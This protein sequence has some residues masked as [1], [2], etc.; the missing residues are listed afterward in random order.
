MK[1]FPILACVALAVS[2]PLSAK[3]SDQ[4]GIASQREAMRVLSWMD[5]RWRGQAVTQ[6]PG[7]EHK[8]VQTER[9]GNFLDGTIKVVE[10]RGFN[11]DGS[12]GFNA[13]GVISYDPAT[14][15]YTFRSYAQGR[16]GTF[17]ISPIAGKPG[18]VWEIPVGPMTIRY[19]ATIEEG[20]WHEVG[21]RISPGA[22]PVR[23]FDMML[24]R[25]GDSD[26]PEAGALTPR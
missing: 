26:W 11:A 22:E 5:G 4:A 15:A 14:K 9:I 19:T 17:T 18:Y 2:A 12:V 20:K 1:P 16:A 13:F 10:G 24:T 8:V 25:V 7:G 6:G 3:I 23:F 21:D